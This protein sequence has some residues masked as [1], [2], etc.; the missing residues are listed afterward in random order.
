M[1]QIL[2]K[3]MTGLEIVAALELVR[4]A[5]E[6]VNAINKETEPFIQTLKD[7]KEKISDDD[8]EKVAEEKVAE[9]VKKSNNKRRKLYGRK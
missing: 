1:K 6:S 4:R 2:V 8:D 7:I 5:M 9:V 3:T